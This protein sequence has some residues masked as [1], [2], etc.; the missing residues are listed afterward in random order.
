MEFFTKVNINH[1]LTETDVDNIDVKSQLEHQIQN[2][3]TKESGWIFDKLNS[4]KKRFE[5]TSELES[6]SYVKNPSGSN[7]I[8]KIESIDNYC[9]LSSVLAYLHPCE[10]SHPLG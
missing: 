10:N 5:K 8:L 6:S 3:E 4:T 1:N 2:Q 7:A 9:F